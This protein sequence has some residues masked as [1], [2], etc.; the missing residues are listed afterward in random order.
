MA[1]IQGQHG[2]DHVCSETLLSE[3]V[4]HPQSCFV[5]CVGCTVAP[6]VCCSKVGHIQ[7][8]W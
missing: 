4:V 2:S 7:L 5:E 3:A 8:L 6:V 1:D